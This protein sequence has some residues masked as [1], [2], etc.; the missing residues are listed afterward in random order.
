MLGGGSSSRETDSNCVEGVGEKL[1][2]GGFVS[3]GF[4]ECFNQFD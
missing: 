1:G 3:F 2:E 4:K